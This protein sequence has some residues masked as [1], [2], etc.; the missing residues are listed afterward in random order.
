MFEKERESSDVLSAAS[1][2]HVKPWAGEVEKLRSI[3]LKSVCRTRERDAHR[4]S[5][6]IQQKV[7]AAVRLSQE[8]PSDEDLQA[9]FMHKCGDARAGVQEKTEKKWDTGGLTANNDHTGGVEGL[10][11]TTHTVVKSQRRRDR[12]AFKQTTASEGWQNYRTFVFDAV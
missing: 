4:R 10:Q 5:Q 8:Q 2:Q 12:A 9:E 1:S 11:R 6:S 7:G 3:Q